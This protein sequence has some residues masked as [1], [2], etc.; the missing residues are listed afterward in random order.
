MKIVNIFF[1][2][3]FFCFSSCGYKFERSSSSDVVSVNIPI[4]K[5]DQKGI[6]TN[7]IIQKLSQTCVL[8]Y[9]NSHNSDYILDA[10]V[11]SISNSKIGYKRER[12]GEGTLKKNVRATEGRQ[13][14]E[15]KITLLDAITKKTVFGPIIVNSDVDYDYVDDDS[16][17]D[18]SFINLAGQ[19]Q[20]VLSFSLGQLESKDSAQEAAIKPL[21]NKLAD[22]IAIIIAAEIKGIK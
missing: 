19:R 1:V 16:L 14:A 20:T 12:D 6:L 4:V 3:L 18:L 5:G 11:L 21:F 22:K 10:E 2:L 7:L 8:K 15:V 17:D 13:A 9:N